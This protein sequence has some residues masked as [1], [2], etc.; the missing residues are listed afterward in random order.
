MASQTPDALLLM[1]THCP[2][3]PSVLAS[4][5]ALLADGTIASL[6]TVNIE[7]QPDIAATFN[8]RTVPWVRI[9]PFELEGMRSLEELRSWADKAGT[10]A[11]LADWLNELLSTGKLDEAEQHLQKEPSLIDALFI[12]FE[13]IETPLNTRIGIS[14]IMESLQG[15]TALAGIGDKLRELLKH[16]EPRI[17]GDACHYLALSGLT[18]AGDWIKPLLEDPDSNVREIAADSLAELEPAG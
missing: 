7:E 12:L 6:E 17:R 5:Q 8:V 16:D 4:L 14:A 2:W 13:D 18:D 11:G 10:T 15:S 1:G 3:C 9:G